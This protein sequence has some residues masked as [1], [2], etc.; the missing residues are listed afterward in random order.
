MQVVG[1]LAQGGWRHEEGQLQ[2][3]VVG[4]PCRVGSN[5]ADRAFLGADGQGGSI[6]V[7]GEETG[8]IGRGIKAGCRGS[9]GRV[10][11]VAPAG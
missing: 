6:A 7:G 5:H 4:T 1:G 11:G 9:E 10:D 2:L 8:G 3:R